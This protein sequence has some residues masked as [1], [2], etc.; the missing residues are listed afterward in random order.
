MLW[1]W[2][3]PAA[4]AL[5]RPPACKLPYGPGIALKR[6]KKKKK[7]EINKRRKEGRGRKKRNK[8]TKKYKTERDGAKKENFCS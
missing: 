7:K 1:L 5:I 6:P 8:Q 4:I 2:H 3:R